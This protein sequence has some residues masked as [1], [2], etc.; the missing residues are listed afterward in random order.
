MLVFFSTDRLTC[1]DLCCGAAFS[2]RRLECDC[3]QA[4][5]VQALA[6]F[7]HFQ[8]LEHLTVRVLQKDIRNASTEQLIQGLAEALPK[9]DSLTDLTFGCLRSDYDADR[10]TD[11]RRPEA[12]VWEL[13]RV[14]SLSVASWPLPR[15]KYSK[16]LESLTVYSH[17]LDDV[18]DL[19]RCAQWRKVS[20]HSVTYHKRWA[21][22]HPEWASGI[23]GGWWPNL[24]EFRVFSSHGAIWP[25]GSARG[26]QNSTGYH[27]FCFCFI[28]ASPRSLWLG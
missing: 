13:P 12:P 4:E 3:H 7:A 15:V 27:R 26:H 25:K 19:L 5:I 16:H 10:K 6:K 9:L 2:L 8:Q 22:Q 24:T 23:S 20:I 21:D 11:E 14:R 28:S 18:S 1:A 17:W